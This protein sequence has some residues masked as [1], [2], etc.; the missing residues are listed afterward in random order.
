MAHFRAILGDAKHTRSLF[1]RAQMAFKHIA[2]LALHWY[3]SKLLDQRARLSLLTKPLSSASRSPRHICGS[4]WLL[5]SPR[6][7]PP[8]VARTP[9]PIVFGASALLFL[10]QGEKLVKIVDSHTCCHCCCYY[11]CAV[12]AGGCSIRHLLVFV[13]AVR[14]ATVCRKQPE[15]RCIRCE[16]NVAH[17]D[18]TQLGEQ[19]HRV[20][21]G[22]EQNAKEWELLS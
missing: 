11:L 1:R 18:R 2:V 21:N 3:K 16:T 8:L 10:S 12:F 19:N 4:R 13:C 9:A 20:G 7:M 6:I 14:I 5:Y 15:M 17:I 22:L